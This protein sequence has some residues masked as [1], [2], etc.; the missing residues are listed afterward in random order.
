M[1]SGKKEGEEA[2]RKAIARAIEEAGS[3]LAWAASV[4]ISPQFAHDIVHGRRDISDA[5][6]ASVG[7]ERV[8]VYRKVRR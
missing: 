7:F 8:T 3:R 6:A 4:G 2:V 5:V 1:S